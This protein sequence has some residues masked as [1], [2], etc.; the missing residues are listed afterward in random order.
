MYSVNCL[1]QKGKTLVGIQIKPITSLS[2]LGNEKI[3]NDIS[4]VQFETTLT[5][6]LSAGI[7]IRHNFSNLLA[8]ETGINY[9]KRKYSLKITD[10]NIINNSIFRI[11]GYEIPALLMIY[12]QLGEKI[13]IN[14]SMGPTMDMFPSSIQTTDSVFNHVAFRN[15]IFQPAISSNLG[16]E[17]RTDKSGIIYLGASFQKPFSFIYL[18]KIG[19]YGNGKNFVVQNELP[20]SYLTID[21]RYFF[22]ET[23]TQ[24]VLE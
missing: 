24:N 4:E 21:F 23:K 19:Y 7:V 2:L 5:S 9:V 10:G 16:F 17:F 3:Y 6:G 18:S 20:G 1:S 15:H 14:G 8:F 22:P 12:A 13:Y 11:I